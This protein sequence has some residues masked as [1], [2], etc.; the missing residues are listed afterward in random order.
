MIELYQTFTFSF[1]GLFVPFLSGKCQYNL[2]DSG[3]LLEANSSIYQHRGF[4]KCEYIIQAPSSR[5]ILLN[6]TAIHSQSDM[7]VEPGVWRQHLQQAA[8]HTTTPVIESTFKT[9]LRKPQSDEEVRTSTAVQ[10]SH[11]VS[12]TA[13]T[14]EDKREDLDSRRH[15][16]LHSNTSLSDRH[17]DKHRT[18]PATRKTSLDNS[19]QEYDLSKEALKTKTSFSGKETSILPG[20]RKESHVELSAPSDID[21][22]IESTQNCSLKVIIIFIISSLLNYTECYVCLLLTVCHALL[23]CSY[24]IIYA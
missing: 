11:R 17:G 19:I 3:H 10:Q 20:T 22:Q 13:S 16:S 5:F 1:I 4:S 8:L 15:K 18:D 9:L 21:T 6:F 7:P 14:V 2:T 24:P 12:E 23:C